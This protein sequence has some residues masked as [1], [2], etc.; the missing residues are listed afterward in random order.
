MVRSV[1]SNSSFSFCTFPLNLYSG[2]TGS[3]LFVAV[4]LV[5]RKVDSLHTC[6][7]GSQEFYPMQES[8]PSFCLSG[9]YSTCGRAELKFLSG[10][11]SPCSLVRTCL[12]SPHHRPSRH[13]RAHSQVM[14]GL[15][16]FGAQ[17]ATPCPCLIPLLAL[18]RCLRHGLCRRHTRRGAS[19]RCDL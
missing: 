8:V 7:A 13:P 16:A 3:T 5:Q 9:N 19:D 4:G 18:Q 14:F 6:V 12:H 10:G 2:R 17:A 1:R 15:G 11:C